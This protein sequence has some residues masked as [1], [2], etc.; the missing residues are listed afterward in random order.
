[1]CYVFKFKFKFNFQL[2]RAKETLLIRHTWRSKEIILL[3]P[4]IAKFVLIQFASV[5]GKRRE[6][7]SGQEK[8]IY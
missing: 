1:M 5:G 3:L 8:P 2:I 7:K 4:I 6:T